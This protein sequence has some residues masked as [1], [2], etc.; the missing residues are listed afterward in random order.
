MNVKRG[1]LRIWLVAS[2]TWVV[3]WA[4][5]VRWT[6]QRVLYGPTEGQWF[7][8]VGFSDWMPFVSDFGFI[9]YASLASVALGVPLT[10]LVLGAGT[11][12]AITGFRFDDQI[13][14]ARV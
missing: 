9:H 10:I 13:D 1:V 12:W 14:H 11:W 4:G 5:Y 8:Y 3:G 2:A 7:C 6:C